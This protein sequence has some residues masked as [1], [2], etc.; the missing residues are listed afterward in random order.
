MCNFHGN[1]SFFLAPVEN[2]LRRIRV[3]SSAVWDTNFLLISLNCN[4]WK[5]TSFFGEAKKW[6]AD[7]VHLSRVHRVTSEVIK[8]LSNPIMT[9]SG[10]IRFS[11]LI[12]KKM[13]LGTLSVTFPPS[14]RQFSGAPICL[15][16]RVLSPH[17]AEE[18]VLRIW[19]LYGIRLQT[20]ERAGCHFFVWRLSPVR[21]EINYSAHGCRKREVN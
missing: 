15:E 7:E 10:T 9:N 6:A 12:V 21:G 3:R 19:Y 16:S 5:I 18:G 11:Y 8:C 4:R 1:H 14:A 20:R 17:A 13:K 2:S